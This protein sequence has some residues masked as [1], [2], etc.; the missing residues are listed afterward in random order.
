MTIL[1]KN[2][3]VLFLPLG[4]SNEI[5]MNLNLYGHDQKWLMVDLGISFMDP[6]M[7]G[8]EV[9][10]PDPKF[11]HEQR[12]QLLGL[13][14]THAHED[15]I[16]AVP[17]LWPQ[18]ECPI[19]ATPFT[20][21]LLRNKLKEAG[22][23]KKAKITL[24]NPGQKIS[25]G[26]F[27][28]E[29]IHITHSIPDS[30]AVILRTK[31]GAILH[32]GDWKFDPGPVVGP[33]SDE[34]ALQSL[35]QENVLAVVGD[36]TNIYTL[37]HSGSE[38]ELA[39]SL[40]NITKNFKYR[41]AFACFASNVARIKTIASIA[42]KIGR[43]VVLAGK[44]LWRINAA[45]RECN[46]LSDMQE[47]LPEEE[48][49]KLPR[50]RVLLICT[51][52]QG[53]ERS[54]LAKIANKTHPRIF[55]EKDDTVI[56][57]S[58][59][60]PGN[61]IVIN[62]LHNKLV[63]LGINI[64]TEKDEFVHV[65][66]H[67]AQEE[68]ATMYRYV[69]PKA[70]IAVHGE[71]HHVMAH[72]KFALKCQIPHAIAGRN[73]TIIRITNESIEEDETVIHNKL[74]LDGTKLIPKESKIF[75]ERHKLLNTGAVF[76]TMIFNQKND[77][78]AKPLINLPGILIEEENVPLIERITGNLWA[79]LKQLS[80]DDRQ[81]DI[82]VKDFTISLIRSML[83]DYYGKKPMIYVHLLRMS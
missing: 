31:L 67:P 11:I 1:P 15:H 70:L 53:E 59:I 78:M 36:S 50:D 35:S 24:I 73:G 14:L 54:A 40:I 28:I 19:Y 26:P 5:G 82:V 56:F 61:E 39:Q 69:K 57:S 8:V 42:Q 43:H 76:I 71:R 32:T 13:V 83:K 46:Y 4:G 18:L 64:I 48:F 34:K 52:S 22:L 77:L 68:L 38:Q 81:K 45:A 10:M 55:L 65:S 7:P 29:I 80:F 23:E 60:I 9:T 30:Y 27:E 37:G 12:N 72:A 47:F 66:G 75:K 6:A 74:G 17:Y 21:S 25:I 33:V 3:E 79:S 51:G 58:R 49:M 41:I 44:S 62:K 16:G 20:A 2:D 63:D